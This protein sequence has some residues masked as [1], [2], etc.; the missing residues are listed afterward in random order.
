M[1]KKTLA[2]ALALM[3]LIMM[4]PVS[5]L[6]GTIT[7]GPT[8]YDPDLFARNVAISRANAAEGMVLMENNGILP[9]SPGTNV[10][11]FGVCARNTIKG[12]GG[13]GDVNTLDADLK[14]I[15][16]GLADAGLILDAEVRNW[17][18]TRATGNQ[19]NTQTDVA[20]LDGLVETAA[21]RNDIA[22]Y[23][24]GRTSSEGG[25]RT[26]SGNNPYNL[27]AIEIA[28]LNRVFAAFDKVVVILNEGAV[29]DVGWIDDY[30]PDAL[31][32][33]GLGGHAGGSAVGD[34][35]T[36]VKNPSG[37]FADTWPYDINDAPARNNFASAGATPQ[38]FYH[39]VISNTG[40]TTTW[41]NYTGVAYP[42]DIYVGYRYYETFNIPVKY[43]FGYGLSYT[44]FALSGL[45]AAVVGDELVATA[46]VTNTGSR[47][48]KE[49]VQVYMSAPDGTLEKPAKELKGYAKTDEL[50]PGQSQTITIKTPVYWLTSYSEDLKA[51]ILDAG[52]YDFY[53]GT[54]V[55]QVDLAGTWTLPALRVVE[56]AD[57]PGAAP[58]NGRENLA[59]PVL[60]KFDD[61]T[62][63]TQKLEKFVFPTAINPG[64]SRP[65]HFPGEKSFVSNE[66]DFPED[67]G[68]GWS[69]TTGDLARNQSD[70]RTRILPQGT[71]WQLI[72][73]YNGRVSLD[74]FVSQF[75]AEDLCALSRG[76]GQANILPGSAAH[77]YGIDFFGVPQS[78]QPDGPAGLR[79]TLN[80]AGGV[81]QKATMFPQGTLNAQTWNTDL[82]F[83]AGM[84][85]GSE[86]AHFG[87]STWLAPGMNIHR[88]PLNGRNFE[89]YSEDPF[90]SGSVAAAVT[91]G[92][93]S[94]GGVAVTLKHFYAN[95]QE[96]G[97]TSVDTLMTERAAREIYLRNFEY[98]VKEA[99]P[100]AIMT[101]YNHINGEHPNQNPG[102]INGIVRGE[103]GFDGIFMYDWGAYGD[104]YLDQPSGINWIMGSATGGRLIQLEN[105]CYYQRDVAEERVKEVLTELMHFRSFTEPNGLPVYEYPEGSLYTQ[106]VSKTAADTVQTAGIA[107]AKTYS[108]AGALAYTVSLANINIGTN[109]ISVSAKFD[110]AKLTYVNSSVEI[111][112]ASVLDRYD[113]ATGIY[114]ATIMLLQRETLFTASASTPVLTVNFTVDGA[115]DV[116][117]ALTEVTVVEL[118]SG[119]TTPLTVICKL[120]PASAISA[121]AP[122]DEDADGTVT[123]ADLSLIIYRYYLIGEGD[124]N[125]GAAQ[126]Y[127]ANGDGIIDLL[128]IMLISTYI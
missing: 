127:D 78:S 21:E 4:A 44:T 87:A 117:G 96:S 63:R 72:D 66:E 31:L 48:G 103:W 12:G 37:K 108:G 121:Y 32:F 113:P 59:F 106:T 105:S 70:Y 89:Y 101:S 122:Y 104:G 40:L 85:V 24:I 65:G 100:R 23:V 28:N 10:A 15:D 79:I 11:V 84:A 55:K 50:A 22:I 74:V 80:A 27:T 9:L 43:E 56:V 25:D 88:D 67:W 97:R 34:I 3:L 86:M 107:A 118:A 5:V 82:L 35:I 91:R 60:S 13:S 36:G 95:N 98:A 112:D 124:A 18:N 41:G 47:A 14:K 19:L 16:A 68:T 99:N 102:L 30:Q 75:S 120:D 57:S 116:T 119:A 42:E 29:S 1:K 58:M 51:W 71:P 115:E 94:L 125:W 38:A 61:A 46:T 76:G 62:T 126:K 111:P 6:A 69:N 93:Q 2:I 83:D 90:L 33:A 45:S 7:P 54:S 73:V 52:A 110:A 53:I 77:T 8:Q 20:I 114:T 128:D 123:L 81:Q 17:Y 49:V 64:T 39:A 26:I 109:V 92:V